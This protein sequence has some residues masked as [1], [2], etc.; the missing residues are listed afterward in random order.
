MSNPSQHSL[1][2]STR[3]IPF[4]SSPSTY[5][6]IP[7]T[8]YSCHSIQNFSHI[9]QLKTFTFL[10]SAFLI[11]HVSVPYNAVA[12]II[13][14]HADTF[15]HIFQILYC[16]PHFYKLPTHYTLDLFCV[17][18]PFRILHP[19]PLTVLCPFDPHLHASSTSCIT[20]TSST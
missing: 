8:I 12:T 11:L 18:Y 2:H 17:Q 20:R 1:I 15:P 14:L 9:S 16:P 10:F 19:L 7:N 6:F 13:F 3:Q 4:Y 5:L